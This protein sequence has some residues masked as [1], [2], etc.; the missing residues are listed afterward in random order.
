MFR[1][2]NIHTPFLYSY[3]YMPSAMRMGM[4]FKIRKCS[5]TYVF[6]VTQYITVC[7][8]FT[9]HYPRHSSMST[10]VTQCH[11]TPLD[12]WGTFFSG[13]YNRS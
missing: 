12:F 1:T 11:S 4:P 13:P 3:M 2:A 10:T 6:F 7:V 8:A 5:P 9:R